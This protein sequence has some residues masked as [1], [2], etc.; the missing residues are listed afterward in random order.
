MLEE[1]EW[2]SSEEKKMREKKRFVS[3]RKNGKKCLCQNDI[4]RYNNLFLPWT[5]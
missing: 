1:R 4:S 2:S 3:E 5:P